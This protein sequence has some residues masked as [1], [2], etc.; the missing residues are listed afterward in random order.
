MFTIAQRLLLY[1]MLIS[2]IPLLLLSLL[3]YTISSDLLLDEVQIY[4]Q[5]RVINESQ[6]LDGLLEQIE[7]L[8]FNLSGVAEIRDVIQRDSVADDAYTR[9]ATQAEIGE[10][11]NS[12]SS[13]RGLVSIDIFTT[14]G[15]HYHV[16]DTLNVDNISEDNRLSIQQQVEAA[17]QSIVWVGV[18]RN[19]NVASAYQNVITAGRLLTSLN[20]ET[21]ETEVI[22]LLLVNYSTE[23]LA[24]LLYEPQFTNT[25]DLLVIDHDGLFIAHPNATRIGTPAE[26]TLIEQFSQDSATFTATYE[27]TNVSISYARS[28]L[29]D[30]VIASVIPIATL[31]AKS[32]GIASTTLIVLI[33]ILA[34]V[35]VVGYS[36]NR[37]VI[38]PIETISRRLVEL[39]S[40]KIDRSMQIQQHSQDEIGELIQG[41]NLLLDN[42]AMRQQIEREREQLIQALEIAKTQAEESARL[43]SE[44]LATMSHEFRTPLNAIEG[45]TGIMLN[46]FGAEINEDTRHMLERIASNSRRLLFLVNDFLDLSRI[47]SGRFQIQHHPFSPRELSEHWYKQMSGLA[48]KKAITLALEIADDVP[49]TLYGDEEALSKVAINLLGNAIKF[50]HKGQVTLAIQ[51]RENHVAWSV[52]DTG[53]GIPAEAQVYIFD[54]FRQVDQ[55]SKRL[56][57]GTGLGLA[58]VKKLVLAM[59]GSISLHSE[60]GVGS[61]FTILLPLHTDLMKEATS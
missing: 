6:E 47:E 57:G 40:G 33:G 41:Y 23:E 30:W 34:I 58:I 14:S 4:N 5:Q 8:I 53:I 2:V 21:M 19:V 32:T 18:E 52:S 3:S 12:Y 55:S 56:Y 31:N 27:Q 16:G 37:A 7:S 22:A 50:T 46:G 49:I 11:L 42:L 28:G 35:A 29:T 13:I 20:R 15:A 24:T 26:P 44:F 38:W 25:G 17:D 39:R 43:K 61:T 59:G 51:R 36:L 45:F 60:I 54:E 1:L 48:D 9:L 10:I